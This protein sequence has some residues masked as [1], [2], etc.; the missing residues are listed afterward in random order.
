MRRS[1]A[2]QKLTEEDEAVKRQLA[3]Y[4]KGK[5]TRTRR[6]WANI[7][8]PY[9]RVVLEDVI[10]GLFMAHAVLLS[11][12]RT[13]EQVSGSSILLALR[14]L[15]LKVTVT[16]ILSSFSAFPILPKPNIELGAWWFNG[17]WNKGEFP[18]YGCVTKA[19]GPSGTFMFNW[20][21]RRSLLSGP[22]S[23][24]PKKWTLAPPPPLFLPEGE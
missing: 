5:W 7:P 16:H 15:I 1:P 13:V 17:V 18:L 9:W 23:T 20:A 19:K 8:A 2:V 21:E 10:P 12:S 24:F 3:L 11:G 6:G 22:V 14:E 4:L